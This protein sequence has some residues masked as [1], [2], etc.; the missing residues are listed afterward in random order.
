MEEKLDNL[1][2]NLQHAM[3]TNPN[4]PKDLHTTVEDIM[5]TA[6]KSSLRKFLT[7]TASCFGWT[8]AMVDWRT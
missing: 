1:V 3:Q 4:I 8:R 7:R 6:C 2:K 5:P